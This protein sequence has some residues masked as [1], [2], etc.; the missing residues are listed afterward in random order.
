M[1]LPVMLKSRILKVKSRKK[2]TNSFCIQF[3][4]RGLSLNDTGANPTT[5]S[6]SLTIHKIAIIL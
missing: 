4:W 5:A 3:L 6:L 1:V 2:Q